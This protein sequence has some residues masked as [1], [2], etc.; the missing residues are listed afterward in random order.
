MRQTLMQGMFGTVAP[1]VLLLLLQTVTSAKSLEE[2]ASAV[3]CATEGAI[4]DDESDSCST[5]YLC[6][7]NSDNVLSPVFAQCPDSTVFSRELRRCVD[8]SA[9]VCE[10]A[11]ERREAGFQCTATGRYPNVASTDCKSYYLCTQNTD[12][13]LIA[14]LVNCPSS[15][16]F[17][18]EKK[19]CVQSPPNI[20]PFAPITT[21]AGP[22]SSTTLSAPSGPFV[23][24]SEGR[25]ENEQSPDC[26]SY[27]LCI[28]INNQILPQLTLCGSSLIFSPIEK[29][30]VSVDGYSCPKLTV[31]PPAL[32]TAEVAT[33]IP[34][35]TPGGGGTTT[36][37]ATTSTEVTSD[38]PLTTP[39]KTTGPEVEI[40]TPTV[41][42]TTTTT[43]VS[44]DSPT[45]T[46]LNTPSVSTTSETPETPTPTTSSEASTT[47][48][49]A[50]TDETTAELP[51]TTQSNPATTTTTDTSTTINTAVS[52]T[53]EEPTTEIT[54][55]AVDQTD[56]STTDS[57]PI[58]TSAGS[59]P[60]TT[61]LRPIATT[62]SDVFECPA[63]GRYPDPNGSNCES[64]I[65]CIRNSLGT[66][67]PL[68]FFCPPTTIFS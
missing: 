25:F 65:L 32:T 61:T 13:S 29:K 54:T 48:S 62:P 59:E 55:S 39:S 34:L 41:A 11:R 20:C 36:T 63:E 15:T 24:P 28:T 9:Y 27:Y 5:Y 53:T 4:P 30:C 56:D 52:S 18:E 38:I 60:D 46:M 57:F 1:L 19:S 6:T 47:S 58:T 8:A 10:R 43:V 17:S 16:I 7:V 23:C 26:S 12:G 44:T 45:S 35:T 67:T 22:Q 3:Q 50:I 64:Y 2:F 21:T 68:Q 31:T 66:L 40:T 42:A 37:A 49:T 14:A 51:T 33:D